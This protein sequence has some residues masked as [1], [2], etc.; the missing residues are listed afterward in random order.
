[1][2]KRRGIG[3]GVPNEVGSLRRG[4]PSAA[5]DHL[6]HRTNWSSPPP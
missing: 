3:D 2:G 5:A 6:R 4:R 1:M